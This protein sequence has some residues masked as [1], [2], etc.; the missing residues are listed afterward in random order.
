MRSE[1]IFFPGA[2]RQMNTCRYTIVVDKACDRM[3]RGKMY[4]CINNCIYTLGSHGNTCYKSSRSVRDLGQKVYVGCVLVDSYMGYGGGFTDVNPSSKVEASQDCLRLQYQYLDA[5]LR[6]KPP[7][8]IK[9]LSDNEQNFQ[10]APATVMS[11]FPVAIST[12]SLV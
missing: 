8:S 5:R 2:N 6:P 7:L 3:V 10:A 11:I 4:G 12:T 9:G 1:V